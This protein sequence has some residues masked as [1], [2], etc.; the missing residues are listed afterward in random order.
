FFFQR[1]VG[2]RFF[3]LAG[4]LGHVKKD[5][6]YKFITTDYLQQCR[7]QPQ[8]QNTAPDGSAEPTSSAVLLNRAEILICR[9]SCRY[10]S[11]RVML[12]DTRAWSADLSS[13]S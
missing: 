1:E 3:R 9:D 13:A 12:E 4:G 11:R 5:T 2:K 6:V 8:A 10:M 7:L